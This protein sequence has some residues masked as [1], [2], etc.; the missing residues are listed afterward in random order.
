MQSAAASPHQLVVSTALPGAAR[1]PPTSDSLCNCCS[2]RKA[3]PL[4]YR[5][6]MKFG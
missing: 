1:T 4:Q 3:S 2:A 5:K 6:S